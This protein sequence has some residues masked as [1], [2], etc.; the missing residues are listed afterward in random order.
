M[1]CKNCKHWKRHEYGRNGF[2]NCNCDKFIDES[3]DRCE[4]EFSTD[5]LLISDFEQYQAEFETGENFGCIHFNP[6]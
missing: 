5:C 6:I 1:K 2:G 3:A 4:I